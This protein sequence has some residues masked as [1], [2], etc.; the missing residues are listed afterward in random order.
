[1]PYY[2]KVT[3]KV[4]EAIVPAYLGV[5]K[6]ADGNYLLYQSALSDIK[7]NTLS[8]RTQR[9][10]GALLDAIQARA[11]IKGTKTP[12][13][14]YTPEEYG[15]DENKEGNTSRS[16]GSVG[17][18]ATQEVNVPHVEADASSINSNNQKE[19]SEVNDD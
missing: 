1:M 5:S 18:K 3:K 12:V 19:E 13:S 15:G 4:K 9:V 7:G 17:T 14:C 6:T 8:E 10:G 11:E 16:S 2:I